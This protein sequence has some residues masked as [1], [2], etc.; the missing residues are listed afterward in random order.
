MKVRKQ[1]LLLYN[2]KI[3]QDDYQ[4]QMERESFLD[5][6]ACLSFCNPHPGIEE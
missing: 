3:G 2:I 4:F 1:F 6:Q 5:A